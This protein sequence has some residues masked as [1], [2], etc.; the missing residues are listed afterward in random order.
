MPPSQKDVTEL[1]GELSKGKR[2]ALDALMP[3][4]Y[5]ELR[6]Q[7]RSFLCH[8]RPDHTLQA[9]ALVHEA[10]MRL[11]EQRH[12]DWQ[13]RAQFYG[14]AAQEMRRILMKHAE[15]HHAQKRGG[16]AQKLPLD[17]NIKEFE[18][19]PATCCCSMKRWTS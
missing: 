4:V 15:R 7:A 8:E 13:N 16:H 17:D 1:L 9:T 6:S 11:V 12:P 5:E 14:L 18:Q 19:Q 10:Y 3:L 2:E